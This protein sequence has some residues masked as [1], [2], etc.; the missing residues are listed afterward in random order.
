MRE[1]A[2]VKRNQ[3]R[4]QE[5]EQ[6]LTAK[7]RPHPDRLAEI[8]IQLTDDLSFART[9]YPQS[10]VTQY[11]NNLA[12]KIHLEI[13]KNKKEEKNRF[14]TFWKHE[15][16]LV[17]YESRKPLLYAF[18]IFTVAILI[19]GISAYHDETFARLILGDAYVNMT[20]ENIEKGNPTAVFS[21]SSEGDMFFSITF[22]N[23][24]VSF[25]AFVAGLLFS[26]GTGFLLFSNGVMVGVIYSFFL[27]KGVA[28][29]AFSVIMLHGT[30]ELSVIVVAGAAG[31][32]MGNGFLFPGTYSRLASF[33]QGV[34]KGV[35]IVMGLVP[36]FIMAGFIESFITRYAFMHW[37]LKTLIIGLSAW[38]IVYYFV[39][40]PY[41]LAHH[42]KH[43]HPH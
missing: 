12:S 10:R 14:V 18:L 19:G 42:G 39:V 5:I 38:L 2:F 28:A 33:R 35:K 40:Y 8:F 1:A 22:N 24:K 25:Y 17:L 27:K 15:L 9:Q 43:L 21:G 41:K 20:L 3:Q 4:W 32:V 6:T 36:F 13:Y 7:G 23:I 29:Q 16:P 30:I 34:L 26:V 31:L 37:G 11:L